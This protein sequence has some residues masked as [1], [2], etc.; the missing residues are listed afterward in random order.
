MN[1]IPDLSPANYS[2]PKTAA[3]FA[4]G[5]AITAIFSG[6]LAT[7]AV[8]ADLPEVLCVGMIVPSFTWVVQMSASAIG[9]SRALRRMYW[10]DLGRIC[11]LGSVALLPAAIVNLCLTSAPLW[12]S[13]VNVLASVAIM[14][15]ALFHLAESHGIASPWPISW[16][17]TIAVNMG[18]FIWS[19]WRW[20]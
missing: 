14:A 15:V 3:W 17:L 10:G 7:K 6:S 11:L 9:L 18:L 4:A 8:H 1:A 20:W 19:S 5:A 16:C 13:A 2:Y 12:M